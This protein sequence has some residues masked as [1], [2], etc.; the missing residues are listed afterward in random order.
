MSAMA[1]IDNPWA[2]RGRV[3]RAEK[4]AAEV[5][6]RGLTVVDAALMPGEWWEAVAEYIELPGDPP[7]EVTVAMAIGMLTMPSPSGLTLPLAH[8][9]L[10]CGLC[11]EEIKPDDG[12]D[13][14]IGEE[15]H[16]TCQADFEEGWERDHG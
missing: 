15:V 13:L 14:H 7:S 3:A 5:R 1:D 2:M 9:R 16:A 4:L 6:R 8:R 12:V 10:L 11:G